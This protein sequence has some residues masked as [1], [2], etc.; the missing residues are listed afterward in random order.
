M[1][2]IIT[3]LIILIAVLPIILDA[4]PNNEENLYK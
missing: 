2:T 3:I 4:E 1:I